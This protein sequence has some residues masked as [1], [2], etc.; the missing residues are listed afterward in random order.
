MHEEMIKDF[1]GRV[2]GRIRF[3]D[4][5]IKEIYDFY[6]RKLGTYDPTTN[7]TKD[8]YGRIVARGDALTMLIKSGN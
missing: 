4:S 5:G 7:T 3:Q 8:F 1:Y 6:G 2:I